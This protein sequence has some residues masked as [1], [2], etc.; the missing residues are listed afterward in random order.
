MVSRIKWR[1]GPFGVKALIFIHGKSVR[2]SGL[3]VLFPNIQQGLLGT[4]HLS[5][6]NWWSACSYCLG[7]LFLGHSHFPDACSEALMAIAHPCQ[8]LLVPARCDRTGSGLPTAVVRRMCL[9]CLFCSTSCLAVWSCSQPGWP[10]K[11]WSAVLLRS[12]KL[13]SGGHLKMPASWAVKYDHRLTWSKS[14]RDGCSTM[15]PGWVLPGK[16]LFGGSLG[17]SSTKPLGRAPRRSY[18]SQ[19]VTLWLVWEIHD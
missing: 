15:G 19:C 16:K 7:Q 17:S 9:A 13:T 10:T 1:V 12:L 5:L 11:A 4:G 6:P 2:L 8:F 18:Y 3:G 14:L